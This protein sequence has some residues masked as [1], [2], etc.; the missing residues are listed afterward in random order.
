[1]FWTA[2]RLYQ[3]L[4]MDACLAVRGV[5]AREPAADIYGEPCMTLNDEEFVYF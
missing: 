2:A 4:A 5:T 1:M 3:F